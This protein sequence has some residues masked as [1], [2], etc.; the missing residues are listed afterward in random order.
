[1]V[2]KKP[3]NKVTIPKEVATIET[4]SPMTGSPTTGNSGLVSSTPK[5]TTTRKPQRKPQIKTQIKTQLAKPKPINNDLTIS[6]RRRLATD[7]VRKL[8]RFE[9]IINKVVKVLLDQKVITNQDLLFSYNVDVPVN[10]VDYTLTVIVK[11]KNVHGIDIPKVT[12]QLNVLKLFP[13]IEV[14]PDEA[15]S[16]V[17][18]TLGKYNQKTK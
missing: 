4:T 11:C 13:N 14:K 6:Q 17:I 18:V 16:L 1:M 8:V 12:S 3:N 10:T 5:K 15:N 7:I 2:I 9:P